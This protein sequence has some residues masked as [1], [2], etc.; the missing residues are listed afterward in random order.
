P[1]FVHTLNG[2]G[3]ATS[4][5]FAAILEQ[6]QRPDGSVVIPEVLAERIGVEVLKPS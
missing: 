2:S 6:N 1:R 4:R 3:L 5:L